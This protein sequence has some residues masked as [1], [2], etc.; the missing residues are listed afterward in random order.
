VRQQTV[1][2][3]LSNNTAVAMILK[4]VRVE[5]HWRRL[6]GQHKLPKLFLA[7][8]LTDGIAVEKR[9]LKVA[10]RLRSLPNFDY[11]SARHSEERNYSG[12][13]S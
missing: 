5:K 2:W 7:V 12:E 9:T 10:A 3:V 13:I 8:T 6:D 1:H 4:F 11:C